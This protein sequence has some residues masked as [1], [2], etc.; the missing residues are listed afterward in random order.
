MTDEVLFHHGTTLVSRLRLAPG[1]ANPV[2]PRS[3]SASGIQINSNTKELR[4]EEPYRPCIARAARQLIR[5]PALALTGV[6]V[7]EQMGSARVP[8]VS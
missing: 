5:Q 2:A 7:G 1:E 6:I 8:E 3:I 4:P